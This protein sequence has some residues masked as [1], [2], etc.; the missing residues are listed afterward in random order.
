[1]AITIRSRF[2]PMTYDEIAAPLIA[3]TAAHEEM[4][5]AYAD[6]ADDLSAIM[7]K[8]NEQ[9]DS[10]SYAKLVNYMNSIQ[11]SADALMQ[12][13][14]SRNSKQALL[15][16]RRKYSNDV[17]PVANAIARREALAQD[18]LK[19]RSA[20]PNIMFERDM[21]TTS[22][23][24]F[25][26]NPQLDYGRVVD[27][28]DIFKEAAALTTAFGKAVS[29]VRQGGNIDK[30]TKEI[31][32]QQGLTMEDIQSAINGDGSALN[33]ALDNLYISSGGDSFNASNQNRLRE[34]IN[35]GAMSGAGSVQAQLVTDREALRR[36]EIADRNHSEAFQAAM[37]GYEW[38]KKNK[39]WIKNGI[40]P[41]G[42]S[43]GEGYEYSTADGKKVIAAGVVKDPRNANNIIV[44]GQDGKYYLR[45]NSSLVQ[46]LSETE[47]FNIENPQIYNWGV[48]KG[49]KYVDAFDGITKVDDKYG[50]KSY[51][52]FI[53]VFSDNDFLKSDGSFGEDVAV[54][55]AED[56]LSGKNGSLSS[57]QKKYF[58]DQ[59]NKIGVSQDNFTII[60][61]D[62]TW[63]TDN[64]Y[65][66]VYKD[67]LEEYKRDAIKKRGDVYTPYK[68]SE[69]KP[70]DLPI[71][72]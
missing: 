15:N 10:A 24:D 55:P 11:Q 5:T 3:Q 51:G 22:L 47:V 52:H 35:R 50:A 21:N 46:E 37:S 26:K 57:N 72:G 68:N 17:V 61:V 19:L 60:C 56:A 16:V 64:D 30:Y 12:K 4:E 58:R 69:I 62:R 29:Q 66:L 28:A 18:Q 39:K 70:E 23:D 13:G 32:T 71:G 45:K 67:A 33:K 34:Y 14:L 48:T 31:L 53:D 42:E 9:T 2:K 25:V 27:G 36:D 49:N 43:A 54:L 20:N 41:S 6:A 1:M 8:V 40:S 59:I 44:V 63:P 65:F 38:D 7:S